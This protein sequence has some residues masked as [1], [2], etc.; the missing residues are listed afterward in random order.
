MSATNNS[1]FE[2][3]GGESA[4]NTLVGA[5]YFNLLGDPRLSVF[6]RG[7]SMHRVLEHQRAFFQMAL[8]GESVY[9]GR[10]LY[11]AH[12]A[13][14]REHGLDDGH[15]D[16]LLQ[17]LRITLLDLDVEPQLATQVLDRVEA[18]REDL[19]GRGSRDAAD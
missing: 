19:F 17:H 15:F 10:N 2:R 5:L 4:V 6:F 9:A 16:L 8:G 1:L 14:I 3:L 18:L 12:E 7:V 11:S 13:L